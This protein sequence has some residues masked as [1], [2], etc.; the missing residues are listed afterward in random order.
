MARRGDRIRCTVM[1][2]N[3][4]V[5]EGQKQVPVLFSLN[6]RKMITQKG[7]ER[8]EGEFFL[9]SDKPLYPYICMTPGCSVLAKVRLFKKWY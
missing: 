5:E 7:E 3:E 4:R 8:E 9:D 2:K 1:F 6:G